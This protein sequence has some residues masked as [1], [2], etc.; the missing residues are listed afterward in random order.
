MTLTQT[1]PVASQSVQLHRWTQ[2]GS[3]NFR[4]KETFPSPETGPSESRCQSC[5]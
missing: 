3:Y 4:F 1:N 5:W 2:R